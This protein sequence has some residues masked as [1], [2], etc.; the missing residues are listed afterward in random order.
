MSVITSIVRLHRWM[1]KLRA[2]HAVNTFQ[3]F[4]ATFVTALVILTTVVSRGNIA[5]FSRMKRS[6]SLVATI[7][8][9]V[10]HVIFVAY[11]QHRL[12]TARANYRPPDP[13]FYEDNNHSSTRYQPRPMQELYYSNGIY[14][15][16]QD[17]KKVFFRGINLPAKTP[18]HPSHLQSTATLTDFYESH[19]DISFV[20][21]D[22]SVSRTC[23][24]WS[25]RLLFYRLFLDSI[26]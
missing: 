25:C 8:L 17:D 16:V 15:T 21:M 4:S 2:D 11:E 18:S 22:S 19:K 20:D 26:R 1:A 9:P 23:E 7:A 6:I 3:L 12:Q 14:R 5:S 13:N 10:L 24:I